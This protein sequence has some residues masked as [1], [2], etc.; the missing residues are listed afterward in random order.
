MTENVE[1]LVLE[2][3]K[4]LRNDV[5]DFRTRFELDVSDLKQRMTGIERGIGGIKREVAEAYDE[6]ARQQAAIDRLTERLDRIE[7]RL[8]LT[9]S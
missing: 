9:S 3:L 5:R 8:E 1:N 2:V 7:K 6:H 4:G